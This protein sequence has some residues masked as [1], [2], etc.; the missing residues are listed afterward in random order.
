MF[1]PQ[2]NISMVY[3]A[4]TSNCTLLWTEIAEEFVTV[5]DGHSLKYLQ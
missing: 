5:Q 4:I 2:G 3:F 1:T